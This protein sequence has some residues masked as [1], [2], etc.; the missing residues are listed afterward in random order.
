ML[1]HAAG[2]AESSRWSC[3]TAEEMLRSMLML[4]VAPPLPRA[5]AHTRSKFGPAS[6]PTF[7]KAMGENIDLAVDSHRVRKIDLLQLVTL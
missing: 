2:S 4:E 1:R 5:R 6:F 7:V 3:R